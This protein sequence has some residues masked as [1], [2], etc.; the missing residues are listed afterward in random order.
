[1]NRSRVA[2]AL[3]VLVLGACTGSKPQGSPS[4]ATSPSA[5][6][7]APGVSATVTVFA[8]SALK[9]AIDKISA[10]FQASNPGVTV[11]VTYQGS[12]ALAT[13]IRGGA[14]A[15]VF[16]GQ[17]AVMD[18][19]PVAGQA[20]TPSVQTFVTDTFEIV[21]GVGNPR[22]IQALG[23]LASPSLGVVLADPSFPPGRDTARILALAGVKVTAKS[24][25]PNT[26]A[27]LTKVQT[28]VADAGIVYTSDVA[29]AG[30]TVTGVA[31][32]SAQNVVEGF[33]ILVLRSA[34]NTDAA[35][36]FAHYAVSAPA[37]AA[38]R[39]LGFGY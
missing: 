7:P 35:A 2:L 18:L 21:V 4:S 19:L 14:A 32:P 10:Q 36:S 1:M 11:T 25:E 5:P 13:A 16:A 22:G 27:V 23:D 28:G 17:S 30:P 38:A 29:A 9:P 24:V 6:P 12:Q 26:P 39:R 31:I 20:V 3:V 33:S 15:D 37:L 34:A 8:D